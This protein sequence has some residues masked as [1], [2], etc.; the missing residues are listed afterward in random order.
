DH[1]QQHLGDGRD[2]VG[3]TR[4]GGRGDGDQPLRRGDQRVAR[5][6]DVARQLLAK[7]P[8]HHRFC[9]RRS[10]QRIAMASGQQ[11]KKYT[12]AM[13]G[14]VS[15]GRKL[16]AESSM[17]RRVISFTEITAPSDENLMSCT[18]LE[19]SG[20]TVMRTA[21]GRTMRR[22]DCTGLSPSTC[23]ASRWPL[24]TAWMPAR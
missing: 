5:H 12:T 8:G 4:R 19:A 14:K 18:K 17:P 7:V 23:A 3:V 1:P 20:G 11:M 15:S 10:H 2:F 13:K 24:G 6:L 16:V 22:N 9:R 21:C